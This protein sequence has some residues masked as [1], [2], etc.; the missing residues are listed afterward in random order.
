[1]LQGFVV[2]NV[3][4][5][6]SYAY[7]FLWGK[8]GIPIKPVM[9]YGFTLSVG[10]FLYLIKRRQ[11]VLDTITMHFIAWAFALFF[12]AGLSSILV[13]GG[14]PEGVQAVIALGEVLALAVV[15][16]LLFGYRNTQRVAAYAVLIAVVCG[17]LINCLDFA[18][19]GSLGLSSVPGRAA[20]FYENSNMSGKYLVFGMGLSV[21]VVPK[22]WRWLYCL[23]VATGVFVTFSRSS[24]M[25]WAL[26]VVLVAWF[27]GFLFSRA[28]SLGLIG[29]LLVVLGTTLVA[30]EW[31]DHVRQFGLG[32]Y[33]D[34][35]TSARISSGF[36]GQGDYSSHE[37]ALVAEMGLERFLQAPF[38]G[39]GIGA[40]RTWEFG[41]ST[42]NQYLQVGAELGAVGLAF[43]LALI[44]LLWRTATAPGRVTALLYAFSCVFTHNNLDSPAM[45]IVWALAVTLG[46]KAAGVV[47]ST[48]PLARPHG[49]RE[50]R[51]T[52]PHA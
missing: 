39:L 5:Y 11:I 12:Y 17:V 29:A 23:L 22:R 47:V 20:G 45:A 25:M 41:V 2:L 26:T 10:M 52:T 35:N 13:S 9:W 38:L 6:Y 28:L 48:S 37:R 44:W 18:T 46:A 7:Q 16:S 14:T 33:L 30:G 50:Q 4:L 31:G 42:H 36:V 49:R 15:F 32:E 40:T 21:G 1:M 27:G 34:K 51:H 24:M 3:A 43:L 8:V 19:K